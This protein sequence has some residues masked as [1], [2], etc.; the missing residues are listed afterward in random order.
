MGAL[1]HPEASHLLPFVVLMATGMITT[2]FSSGFDWLYP[3]RVLGT[4]AVLLAYWKGSLREQYKRSLTDP[5]NLAL[6]FLGAL[7]WIGI[8]SAGPVPENGLEPGL[9]LAGGPLVLSA[10]W[11][12]F[13]LVGVVLVVPAAEELAFRSYLTR[14]L[15]SRDFEKVRPGEFNW[16]SFIGSS[17]LFGILHQ[18]WAAGTVAGMLFAL[19]YYRRGRVGDAIVAHGAANLV[20]AIFV[21]A[22]G[23]W[24]LW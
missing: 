5:M 8:G 10:A 18:H 15:I 21:S 4:G 24:G 22:T 3:I 23:R 2:A 1:E 16:F 17:V 20:L 11:V 13:R 12:F 6:G 19:A 7:I 14:R 9:V